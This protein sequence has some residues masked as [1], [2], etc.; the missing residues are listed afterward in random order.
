MNIN[1]EIVHTIFYYNI[2]VKNN[3]HTSIYSYKV[4]T[5][6]GNLLQIESEKPVSPEELNE[7]EKYVEENLNSKCN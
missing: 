4:D 3:E 5:I 1:H 2:T 6:N 7:V